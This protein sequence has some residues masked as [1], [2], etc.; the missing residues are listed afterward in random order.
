[1]SQRKTKEWTAKTEGAYG[2]S[3]AIGRRGELL[4]TSIINSKSNFTVIDYE[5]DYQMQ[6]AGVDVVVN[7]HTIDVK[8]NLHNGVFHIERGLAGWLFNAN[9]T[10]DVIVHI[11]LDSS[12]I[13]WYLRDEAR[14]SVR[15]AQH[16]TLTRCDV[17]R[18]GQRGFI[19]TSWEQL[20]AFLQT[21]N[22]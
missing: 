9:K 11:D 16:D 4:F 21:S 8:A 13:V 19:S 2:L 20:L 14:K 10:S 17:N 5:Q 7:G 12:D 3:G 22:L 6:V 1:M 18:I 15:V